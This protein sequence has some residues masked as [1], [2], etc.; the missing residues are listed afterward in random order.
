M[1][2][3]CPNTILICALVLGIVLEQ[4]QV[5]GKSCC[6]STTARNCYN[7]CRLPGVDRET[8]A[9]LCG[10]KIIS[11]SKCPSGWDKLNL[12][13]N[14]GKLARMEYCSL[15]CRFIACNN[16]KNVDGSVERCGDAC[17][18]ICNEDTSTASV[19]A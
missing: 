13:P 12:L 17:D 11:E 6:P 7:I 1:G 3:K 18:R 2:A 16:I 4:V 19:V 9:S 8:C 5:E 15:G 14:Y 10:C